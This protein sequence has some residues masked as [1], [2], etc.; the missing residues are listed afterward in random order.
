MQ[1]MTPIKSIR[2][3]CLDCCCGQTQEVRLCPSQNCALWLYRMGKRP[4][5]PGP[6]RTEENHELSAVFPEK[7]EKDDG[8]LRKAGEFIGRRSV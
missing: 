5:T 7:N 8:S 3:K 4:A 2:A 1:R 6:S